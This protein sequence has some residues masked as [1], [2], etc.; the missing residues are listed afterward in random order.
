M[1]KRENESSAAEPP[2]ARRRCWRGDSGSSLLELALLTPFLLTLMMGIVE[3]G[4]YAYYSILVANAAREGAQYGAQNVVTAGDAAGIAQAATGD[5]QSF[6]AFASHSVTS[7]QQ[8]GCSGSSLSTTCP[9]TS[10]SSPDH[11]LV[12]EVVTVSGTVNSMTH[13]PGIPA[14][15]SLQNTVKMR[16]AQ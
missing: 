7:A 14:S 5:G 13:F 15:M 10:C 2:A 16:V 4:R 6:A 8:C 3:L 11:P 9:A 12:Y 1:M